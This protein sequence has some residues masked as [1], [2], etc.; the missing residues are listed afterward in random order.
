MSDTQNWSA[1]RFLWSG[2]LTL[3][4]LVF[5][6]GAWSVFTSIAGAIVAS[7]VIEVASTRQIV[8]HGEGG[9]VRKF[10]SPMATLLPLVR[11][12]SGSMAP[13]CAPNSPS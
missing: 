5:G 1:K 10:W 9:V 4:V 13:C 12:C 8:Q 2:L 7:G 11:C 6:L 3:A